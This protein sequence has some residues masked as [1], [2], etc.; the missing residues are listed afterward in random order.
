MDILESLYYMEYGGGGYIKH[1]YPIIA[2]FD[3]FTISCF[4]ILQEVLLQRKAT[5][6]CKMH[7]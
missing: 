6:L 5:Q 2:I 4:V 7:I 1:P 3:I